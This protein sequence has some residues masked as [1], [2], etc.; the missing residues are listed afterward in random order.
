MSMQD[1]GTALQFGLEQASQCY[2]ILPADDSAGEHQA[3]PCLLSPLSHEQVIRDK[4]SPHTTA[5]SRLSP[6]CHS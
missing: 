1:T 4:S 3:H 2:F 5:P 6:V